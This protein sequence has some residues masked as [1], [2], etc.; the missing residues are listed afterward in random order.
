MNSARYIYLLCLILLSTLTVK[1]Q[2][3][4]FDHSEWD[5]GTIKEV[6]GV[7][8]HT[9]RGVN[10]TEKPIV[11]TRISTS[12]GC[13]STDHPTKPIAPD[14]HFEIRVSFDPA[15]RP[16]DFSKSINIILNGDKRQTLIIKGVVTP[17]P[18]TVEDDYPYYMIEGLRLSRNSFGFGTIQHGGVQSSVV[19]YINTSQ[20]TLHPKLFF[21]KQSG[22][23][24]VELPQSIAPGECG[25]INI[26]Y[27]LT[28]ESATYGRLIDKFGIEINDKRS[29]HTIYTAAIAVDNFDEIDYDTAPIASFSCHSHDFGILFFGG[30]KAHRHQVTLT[31]KGNDPLIIRWIENKPQHFFITLPIGTRLEREES[32][33]FD[34]VLQPDEYG[35]ADIFDAVS[36]ITNDPIKPYSQLKARAKI[37]ME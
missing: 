36:I 26:M 29:H 13:T 34:M 27:D 6:D 1:G 8:S 17:R 7:V 10:A 3:L 21:E 35:S 37:T 9:F 4:T 25:Q 14:E 11:I 33:T 28:K 24:K 18:K 30:Q 23:L 19:E 32:I 20:H 22:L 12:C 2:T 31:N 5:F 16:E 15:G